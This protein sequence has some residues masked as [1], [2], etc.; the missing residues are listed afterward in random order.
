ML[1]KG[2]PWASA[3]ELNRAFRA[4][5]DSLELITRLPNALLGDDV[6]LGIASA[7]LCA[8][9]RDNTVSSALGRAAVRLRLP[10]V[11]ACGLEALHAHLLVAMVGQMLLHSLQRGEAVSLELDQQTCPSGCSK[12]IW[13]PLR[14]PTPPRK[15]GPT[16]NRGG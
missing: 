5:W 10:A 4:A 1:V 8:A 14:N 11:K 6:K 2:R 15:T 9:L 16:A 13:R 12:K 3:D 7:D